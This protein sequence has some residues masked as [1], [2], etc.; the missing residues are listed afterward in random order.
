MDVSIEEEEIAPEIA[1]E[2]DAMEDVPVSK[3]SRRSASTMGNAFYT[4]RCKLYI[5]LIPFEKACCQIKF[6]YQSKVCALIEN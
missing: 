1:Q 2:V 6:R 3:V 4:R 5:R